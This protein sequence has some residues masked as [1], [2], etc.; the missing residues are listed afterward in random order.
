MGQDG[1][2]EFTMNDSYGDGICCSYGEGSYSVL[3]Q[4][5]VEVSGGQF[6][7]TETTSFGSETDCDS[8]GPVTPPPS[9]PPSSQPSNPANHP[10]CQ[11]INSL[12]FKQANHPTCQQANPRTYQ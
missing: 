9:S 3:R 4:G 2:F 10:T 8:S 5:T 6:G 11:R 12:T 7:G 1:E